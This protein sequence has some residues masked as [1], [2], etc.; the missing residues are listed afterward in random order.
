MISTV[1]LMAVMVASGQAVKLP[2]GQEVNDQ[3]FEQLGVVEMM[4]NILSGKTPMEQFKENDADN[5]GCVDFN[6]ILNWI[7]SHKNSLNSNAEEVPK[8]PMDPM[9]AKTM[10]KIEK[11]GVFGGEGMKAMFV[12]IAGKEDGCMTFD[13]LKQWAGL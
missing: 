11:Q 4:A 5:N 12:E 2:T 9:F 7:S 10:E 1:V 13:Q 8:M 3:R 6:E